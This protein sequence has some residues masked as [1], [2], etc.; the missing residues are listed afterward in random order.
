VTIFGERKLSAPVFRDKF[1]K[2]QNLGIQK[3]SK[4]EDVLE[5]RTSDYE[6]IIINSL[7]FFV[8]VLCVK[9]TY[10]KRDTTFRGRYMKFIMAVSRDIVAVLTCDLVG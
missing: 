8:H 3:L 10:K 1:G 7:V 9:R 4:L 2:T 6:V 5:V